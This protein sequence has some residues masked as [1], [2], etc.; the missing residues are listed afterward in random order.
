MDNKAPVSVW[1]AGHLQIVTLQRWAAGSSWR[2]SPWH[3][4]ISKIFPIGLSNHTHRWYTF[5]RRM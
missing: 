4:S 2:N 3:S 1:D 5:W